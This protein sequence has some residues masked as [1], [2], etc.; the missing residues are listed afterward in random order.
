MDIILSSGKVGHYYNVTVALQKAGVLKKFITTSYFKGLNKD[1]FLKKLLIKISK[2]SAY[3][4]FYGNIDP[5]LVK[6]IYYPEVLRRLLKSV[7]FMKGGVSTYL[8]NWI[9]DFASCQH[10]EKSDIFFVA[11]TYGFLSAKKA[12]NNGSIV[13]LDV[14]SAHPKFFINILKEEAKKFNISITLNY[15]YYL[16]KM[17]KEFQLADFILVPS[18][19][20]YKTFINEGIG[21]TKLRILPYGADIEKFSTKPKT[22]DIF[23]TIFVGRLSIG[24]GIQYLLR[25]FKELKLKNSEL[26]LVGK[27]S[28]H[29][30]PILREYEG[31][32]K[33]IPTIPHKFINEYYCN[34]S[35]LVMPSLVEGSSLVVYEAMAC[36][37]PVIVTE[38]CGS[39]V[40]D[41]K[42][43]F[44]I[45]IR[46]LEALKEKIVYFYEN[47]SVRVK[48]GKSA[49]EHV[50]QYTWER[51]GDN[52]IN[53]FK[54]IAK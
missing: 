46:D 48:M 5:N 9:F 37:L 51:Y 15:E 2:R 10:I 23:R 16:E 47:E 39:I 31:C 6:P 3:N 36:G 1:N 24:K 19:F 34:S 22:D 49:H 41:G 38:N 52:L 44:V 14:V 42:D 20:V 30:T 21:A 12:K 18:K 4:R 28:I 54:N 35:I 26:L 33:H 27:K 8:Y 17:Q 40:R 53:F 13:V 32:F 7:P 50:E 43:G 25:A 29:M 45:P 11:S